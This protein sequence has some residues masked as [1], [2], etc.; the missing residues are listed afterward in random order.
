MLVAPTRVT[1]QDNGDGTYTN[2]PLPADYPDPDVIRVGDDFYFA[3]TTFVNS[4]GLVLLHS[5][6][7]V[8]WETVGYDVPLLG[9]M[10][11]AGE[12]LGEDYYRAGG[13]PAV[14]HELLAAGRLHGDAP[15]INGK[16][17]GENVA[18]AK[19]TNAG[20]IRSYDKLC[21]ALVRTILKP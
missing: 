10:Q 20:V 16:T 6:D 14:M 19:A 12:Y 11:P 2:P 9:N 13:L 5:K 17:I 8:N 15:T 1:A 3:S 7:L 4:P 21:R 18:H